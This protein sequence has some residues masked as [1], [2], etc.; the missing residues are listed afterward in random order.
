MLSFHSSTSS[1]V[2]CTLGLVLSP[3]TYWPCHPSFC[4]SQFSDFC[5][6]LLCCFPWI[7][8]FLPKLLPS[9]LLLMLA[10]QIYPPRLN[11]SVPQGC[12]HQNGCLSLTSHLALL[13][14]TS[15]L[16]SIRQIVL[17]TQGNWPISHKELSENLWHPPSQLNCWGEADLSWLPLW[18]SLQ[19]R[20]ATFHQQDV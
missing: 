6:C 8:S 17:I 11:T 13:W 15:C 10:S 4:T 18:C 16:S 5:L 7:L 2:D 19:V 12:R 3:C 9:F 1:H 20:L 14:G